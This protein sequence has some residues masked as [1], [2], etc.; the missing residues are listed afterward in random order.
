MINWTTVCLYFVLDMCSVFA[1]LQ[2]APV[3]ES[4]VGLITES[5]LY[6]ELLALDSPSVRKAGQGLA[7]SPELLFPL[8]ELSV[9]FKVSGS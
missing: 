9:V 1:Q 6:V 4:A 7:D 2:K 3:K 5:L 8:L